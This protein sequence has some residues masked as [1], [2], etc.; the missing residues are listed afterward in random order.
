[1]Y[2]SDYGE[3]EWLD[4]ERY[5]AEP[6]KYLRSAEGADGEYYDIVIQGDYPC[7]LRYTKIF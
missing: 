4:P 6:W 1:M 5:L 3:L 7:E 2:F